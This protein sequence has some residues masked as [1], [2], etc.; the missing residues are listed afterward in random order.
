MSV[1]ESPSKNWAPHITLAIGTVA[2]VLVGYLIVAGLMFPS[3]IEHDVAIEMLRDIIQ[4]DGVLIA[5]VG[6][7]ATL[8]MTELSKVLDSLSRIQHVEL[9]TEQKRIVRSIL[10][11]T[12]RLL[13]RRWVTAFGAGVTVASF[14]ISILFCLI[15]MSRL[16]IFDNAESGIFVIPI[17]TMVAGIAGIFLIFVLAVMRAQP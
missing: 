12:T 11:G 16:R 13:T 14:V 3:S 6:L 17:C 8:T 7:T 5:F 9:F 15:A 4:V 1:F 2:V 10:D